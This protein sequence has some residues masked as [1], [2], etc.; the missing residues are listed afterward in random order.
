[1]MKQS[2]FKDVLKRGK[3][4]RPKDLQR[5]V[6]YDTL[7]EPHLQRGAVRQCFQISNCLPTKKAPSLQDSP[8]LIHALWL[9]LAGPGCSTVNGDDYDADEEQNSVWFTVRSATELQKAGIIF[10]S[11]K[12]KGTSGINF[13]NNWYR[14][15]AYL[16]LP[17]LSIEPN[18][19]TL[20]ESLID[21]EG[22]IYPD[23]SHREVCA[24]L[25]FICEIIRTP[26]DAK[27]LALYG[28]IH[29]DPESEENL[30][31]TL[32]SVRLP[33]PANNRKWG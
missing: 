27:V 17:S 11:T 4:K 5:M 2:F 21:Y 8:T 23:T 15:D 14:L 16:Y 31:R 13:K 19:K 12:E 1:M 3:W 6:L 7:V 18:T 26:E 33:E 24:Y 10:R 30:T 32:D 28:I 9:L 29:A 25:K 22:E 20:F